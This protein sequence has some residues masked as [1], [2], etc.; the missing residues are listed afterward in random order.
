M[1]FRTVVRAMG[2]GFPSVAIA[3]GSS[4]AD[5]P[6]DGVTSFSGNYGWA[7]ASSTDCQDVFDFRIEPGSV[8]TIKVNN[9]SSGSVS[10]LALYAPGVV[11]GGVNL[12]TGNSR[13]LRCTSA[14]ACEGFTAGEQVSSYAVAAGGTYRIA[15]TREWDSSCGGTGTYRLAV[16]ATKNFQLLGQTK[17]D[18]PSAAIG[19]ECHQ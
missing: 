2:L 12:L 10:Q 1:R 15:V 7:C 4:D 6:S 16:T 17:E 8:I 14:S 9:V 19:F 18:T 3:C 11:L 5:A 13:E